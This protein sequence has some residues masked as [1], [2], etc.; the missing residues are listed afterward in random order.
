MR[1]T[2]KVKTA[3]LVLIVRDLVEKWDF[4]PAYFFCWRKRVERCRERE[5]RERT[6]LTNSVSN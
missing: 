5:E 4:S 3:K 2:K 6:G 1:R